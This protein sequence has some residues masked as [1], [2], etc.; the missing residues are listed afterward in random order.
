MSDSDDHQHERS[1]VWAGVLIALAGLLMLLDL[2]EASLYV[3]DTYSFPFSGTIAR[4]A[5]AVILFLG[6]VILAVGSRHGTRLVGA[7]SRT[8][9]LL[10]VFGAVSLVDELVGVVTGGHPLAR[11]WLL[12]VVR[13]AVIV[14]GLLAATA[15]RRADIADRST[16]L[17]L[18]VAAW[19]LV[20][21][22]VFQ[23]VP[24]PPAV[25]VVTGALF[26]V[27]L[28][29]LGV[30]VMIEGRHQRIRD[31]LHAARSNW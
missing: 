13:V 26:A 2:A 10:V 23:F 7:S 9:T 11:A 18:L 12:I 4:L 29:A 3:D 28:L 16:Q 19:L 27:S 20:L 5:A 14:A 22:T 1:T 15:V 25:A 21:T 8:A 31:R 17:L 24:V 30:S 6:F